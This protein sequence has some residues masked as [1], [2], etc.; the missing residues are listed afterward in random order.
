[1]RVLTLV[2]AMGLLVA[3]C[4][5]GPKPAGP[6][7]SSSPIVSTSTHP[8][9]STPIP[10]A[11]H[12][13]R[14]APTP[15]E[16][17][18]HEPPKDPMSRIGDRVPGFGGVCLDSDQNIVHIYPQDASVQKDAERVVSEVLGPDLLT[19]SDPRQPF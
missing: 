1:M 16:P 15:L 10:E 3:S 8:P 13:P 18:A 7:E 4:D 14:A 9:A 2:I 5:D 12:T 17:A 6:R 19:G 11:T